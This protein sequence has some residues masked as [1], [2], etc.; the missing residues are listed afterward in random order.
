MGSADC[1]VRGGVDEALCR[2]SRRGDRGWVVQRMRA[3][4]D[5]EAQPSHEALLGVLGW[6]SG[7]LHLVPL[8]QLL[9]SMWANHALMSLSFL[10]WE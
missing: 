10:N 1:E 5:S 2:G 9:L 7:P 4:D 6:V 8:L 3:A